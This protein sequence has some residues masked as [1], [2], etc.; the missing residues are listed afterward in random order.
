MDFRGLFGNDPE[1]IYKTSAKEGKRA[2][3]NLVLHLHLN[4]LAVAEDKL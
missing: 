4:R 3:V 2:A 1:N